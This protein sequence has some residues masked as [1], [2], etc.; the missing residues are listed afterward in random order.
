M[1]DHEHT[2][3]HEHLHEHGAIESQDK[4]KAL[5]HYMYH[6]NVEHTDELMPLAQ[7][8]ESEG[9]SEL[10]NKVKQAIE[11]YTKGNTLLDEVLKELP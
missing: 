2:H 4:L 5:L 8:L 7:S 3:S 10:A 1:S 6:H 9:K 11:E